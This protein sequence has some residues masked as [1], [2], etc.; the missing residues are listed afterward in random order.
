LKAST[1][2]PI[3]ETSLRNN[4]NNGWKR[5]LALGLQLALA[6]IFLYSSIVKIGDLYTFGEILRSY[7]ILPE[8]LI[9]PFAVMLPLFELLCGLGLLFPASRK[10]SAWVVGVLSLFFLVALAANWGKVLPYGCGCFGPTE[11]KPVGVLDLGKDVL[12][13]AMAGLLLFLRR[14]V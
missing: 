7:G 9:K 8:G 13:M 12:F 1:P 6:A 3:S 2:N 14:K 11:A 10:I 4:A 5:W